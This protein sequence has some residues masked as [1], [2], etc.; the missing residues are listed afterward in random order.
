M[1]RL[2]RRQREQQELKQ[3]IVQAAREIACQEGWSNVTLRKI[4]DKI[5]YSHAALYAYFESKDALLL[6]ILREGFRLL[7]TDMRAAMTTTDDAEEA[8]YKVGFAY[9]RFAQQNTE[10]YQV[11]YGLNGISFGVTETRGE[12]Q[13]VGDVV[14]EVVQKWLLNHNKP[15]VGIEEKVYLLWSTVHGL[16]ALTMAGRL[17]TDDRQREALVRQSISQALI[18]W[19]DETKKG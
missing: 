4:A 3:Q 5:E 16:I 6:E 18:A 17:S 8:L 2:E 14:G 10:L 1:T 7:T 12:G 19:L 13:Q 9:W 11:M 15:V